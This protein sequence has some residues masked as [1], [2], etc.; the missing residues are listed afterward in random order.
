MDAYRTVIES[1]HAEESTVSSNNL[2][3]VLTVEQAANRLG[4]GR[5]LMYELVKRGDV[6]SVSIG[7]LRRIPAQCVDEYVARLLGQTADLSV[8]A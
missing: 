3:V 1:P 8:A 2:H 6:R 7:R 4:I 5:T